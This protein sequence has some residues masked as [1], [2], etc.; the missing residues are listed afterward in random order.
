MTIK[1]CSR[2][3]S[4]QCLTMV[5]GH[6]EEKCDVLLMGGWRSRKIRRNLQQ[7]TD[8]Y[9]IIICP[10]PTYHWTDLIVYLLVTGIE[11][12]A[13]CTRAL[14]PN[15]GADMTIKQRKSSRPSSMLDHGRWSQRRKM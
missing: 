10:L 8:F 12:G 14:I 9:D 6:S 15:T 2:Q 4:H 11:E 5:D 3:G 13:T 1:Q 7:S